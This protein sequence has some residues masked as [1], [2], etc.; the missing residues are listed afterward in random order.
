MP[1]LFNILLFLESYATHSEV[2]LWIRSL[3]FVL[4]CTVYCSKISSVSSI[5]LDMMQKI[6]HQRG[7]LAVYYA[8]IIE[9]KNSYSFRKQNIRSLLEQQG[10]KNYFYLF[11]E[12]S[13]LQKSPKL[14]FLTETF[15]K[16]IWLWRLE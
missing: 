9:D 2:A 10:V 3:I 15:G 5:T 12:V 6:N 8:K 4:C 11:T 7:T 1:F 13:L 16:A 14:C